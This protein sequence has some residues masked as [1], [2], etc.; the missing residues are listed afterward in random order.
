MTTKLISTF[1]NRFWYT[2]SERRDVERA[3]RT[4][5]GIWW[6][7]RRDD[8]FRPCWVRLSEYS[9]GCFR[10]RDDVHV[11]I[12]KSAWPLHLPHYGGVAQFELTFHESELTDDIHDLIFSCCSVPGFHFASSLFPESGEV[13]HYAWTMKGKQ[14]YDATH[15]KA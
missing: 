14:H 6:F 1:K 11:P 9:S 10:I 8:W 7:V 13:P 2:V 4:G 3:G 5:N 15:Q 12:P